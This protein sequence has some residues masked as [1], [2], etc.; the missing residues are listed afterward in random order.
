MP[1]LVILAAIAAW[2]FGLFE[3][4]TYTYRAEVGY[5]QDGYMVWHVGSDKS[6]DA[7]IAEAKAVFS[8]YNTER[9]GRAFAWSCRR[10]QGERFI[11]RIQ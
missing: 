8:S 9:P 10:M 5:Y 1:L 4:L 2:Y 6:Y 11:D 7:C 3:G